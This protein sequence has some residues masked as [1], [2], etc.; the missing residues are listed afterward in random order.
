MKKFLVVTKIYIKIMTLAVSALIVSGCATT[1]TNISDGQNLVNNE[2]LV[3]T[4]FHTQWQSKKG[5]YAN[6]LEFYFKKE[7]VDA[8]DASFVMSKAQDLK[9]VALPPGRYHWYKVLI[10][11]YFMNLDENDGF[12]VKSGQI[13]Y[14]GDIYSSFGQQQFSLSGE[15]SVSNNAEMIKNELQQS[16][17]RLMSKYEFATQI[18]NINSI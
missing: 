15:A 13:T 9:V 1:T 7:G 8:V 4:K 5:S 6:Y 17:P 16:H 18:T 10:G 12:T 3:V 11:D 14:I 2:G